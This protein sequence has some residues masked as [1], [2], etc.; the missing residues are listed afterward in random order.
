MNCS[1]GAFTVTG[2]HGKPEWF[3]QWELG[4]GS[5]IRRGGSEWIWLK[6]DSMF[7]SLLWF[8]APIRSEQSMLGENGAQ[9]MF[10]KKQWERCDL[11][12]H[13]QRGRW[14]RRHDR[15]FWLVRAAWHQWF[16]WLWNRPITDNPEPCSST[17][18]D[19][20]WSFLSLF[21]FF[22]CFYFQFGPLTACLFLCVFIYFLS[23]AF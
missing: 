22:V 21:C 3:M 11:Q 23:R 15:W 6:T 13:L 2:N 4:G 20:K 8:K 9:Q 7:V 17:G 18:A 10:I 12:P 5:Q 14:W 19:G 16:C 1:D